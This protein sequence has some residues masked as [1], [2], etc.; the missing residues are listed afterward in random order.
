[1]SEGH[2]HRPLGVAGVAALE[3]HLAHLVGRAAT[4]TGGLGHVDYRWN[5]AR[6]YHR[7]PEPPDAGM[8]RSMTAY[9]SG[10]RSTPWGT[11]A[12]ELRA[13]NHRFLELGLRAPD[14]LRVLAPQ[15]RERIAAR[16]SRGKLELSLR[17]RPAEGA[18][19]LHVDEA[20]LDQLAAIARDAEG[21]FPG[22]RTQFTELLQFPGVLRS[23]APEPE[24][25]QAEVL[26]LLEEVLD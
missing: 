24:A 8:I 14:E 3:R 16:V 26:A 18:S 10:E 19:A 11:L 15:L 17:L 22:L 5:G 25:L 20:L 6:V 4:G 21:R 12:C 23:A 7:H 1:L 13:V 9:A 2:Q